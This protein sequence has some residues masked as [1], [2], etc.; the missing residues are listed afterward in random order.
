MHIVSGS[1]DHTARVWDAETHQKIGELLRSQ[2]QEAHNRPIHILHPNTSYLSPEVTLQKDGWLVGPNGELLLWIPHH[3]V[4]RLP[5]S[6]LLGICGSHPMIK[7]DP[8]TPFYHG[9]EWT[10]CKTG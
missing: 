3:L 4:P 6:F 7:F 10:R 8:K 9:E 5:R 1:D 2:A